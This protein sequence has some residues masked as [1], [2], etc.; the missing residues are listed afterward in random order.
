[1]PDREIPVIDVLAIH[2][3]ESPEGLAHEWVRHR[4]AGQPWMGLFGKETPVVFVDPEVLIAFIDQLEEDFE[5][6]EYL[7]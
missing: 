1:M 3:E 5:V 7:V 2:G 4:A 6:V